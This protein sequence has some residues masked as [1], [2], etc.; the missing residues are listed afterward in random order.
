M[1]NPT[2]QPGSVSHGT[3]RPE[4]LIPTFLQYVEE[5]A[6]DQIPEN[7]F[8]TDTEDDNW[9]LEELF[10]ILE[11]ISPPGHYFGSHPGDGADYGW[12]PFDEE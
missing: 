8:F 7:A 12:W 4:D 6:P 11:G 1:A 2:P 3:L 9:L 5:F 10:C